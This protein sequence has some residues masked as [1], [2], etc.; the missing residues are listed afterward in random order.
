METLAAGFSDAQALVAAWRPSP[1][2]HDKPLEPLARRADV[3]SLA[4]YVTLLACG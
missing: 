4:G 1:S 3:A 2:H